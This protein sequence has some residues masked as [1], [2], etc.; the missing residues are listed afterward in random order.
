MKRTCAKT[1]RRAPRKRTRM[2]QMSVFRIL[3]ND[4]LD[5]VVGK[6]LD[7]LVSKPLESIRNFLSFCCTTH[8]KPSPNLYIQIIE[9]FTLPGTSEPAMLIDETMLRKGVS[10]LQATVSVLHSMLK[11]L[12]P[13][14]HPFRE[15]PTTV[16][17]WMHA[18]VF[19]NQSRKCTDV[20]QWRLAPSQVVFDAAVI[21]EVALQDA[22]QSILKK[23]NGVVKRL[24]VCDH[25][26]DVAFI[27]QQNPFLLSRCKCT[28]VQT[29][30]PRLW[31]DSEGEVSPTLLKLLENDPD[32]LRTY[33]S[34]GI[35]TIHAIFMIGV[36]CNQTFEYVLQ[37][38][39]FAPHVRTL[40][41]GNTIA[42][43]L[44][45]TL[46]PV[47]TL[48]YLNSSLSHAIFES[49]L[50]MANRMFEL[51]H[52]D[53]NL[54]CRLN[55]NHVQPWHVISR[56]VSELADKLTDPTLNEAAIS[57]LS[58]TIDIMEEVCATLRLSANE[59]LCIASY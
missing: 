37:H 46:V 4:C 35:P 25:G 55:K 3:D 23:C 18:Y 38:H 33:D 40:L 11:A 26:R 19:F 17:E 2:P 5:L 36:S 10:T 42:H 21:C 20:P 59:T 45:T 8:W 49:K 58:S 56:S 50:Y 39:S 15:L 47:H 43:S 44:A 34:L 27:M 51:H 54:F 6:M 22:D 14:A 1:P 32:F 7:D 48:V 24:A 52:P 9:A 57:N 41:D 16:D 12:E 13:L 53:H 30:W 31:S 29:K 28:L